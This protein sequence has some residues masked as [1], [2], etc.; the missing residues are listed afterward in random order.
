V[1]N[2]AIHII[3]TT[4]TRS[5][6]AIRAYAARSRANGKSDGETR[7]CLKRYRPRAPPRPH[8]RHDQEI[9]Q[10]TVT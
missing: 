1:L 7:R 8:H 4:R 5:D 9:S 10:P 6:P 2:K 3:A